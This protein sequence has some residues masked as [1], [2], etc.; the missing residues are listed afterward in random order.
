MDLFAITFW[1]FAAIIVISAIIVVTSKNIMYSAFSLL[2]TFFGVAGIYVM[3]NADFLALTQIMIYIGGI[4]VLI[5]FGVMLTS[6]VTGVDIKEGITGKIQLGVTAA[7]TA[8]IA[9]TLITIYSNA[10]WFLKDSKPL[11]QT[12]NPIGTI[13]L[14]DYLLAFEVASVLLLVAI[15]GA[16]LIART[17]KEIEM[18]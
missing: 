18:K 14:T 8:I 17:K 6:K 13:L 4:L 5:I 15:V 3:L 10:K 11:E 16:A 2:F 9:I 12:I 7:A 1:A